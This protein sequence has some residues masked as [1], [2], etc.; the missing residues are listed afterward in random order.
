MISL[1][2]EDYCGNC[3]EFEPDLEKWDISVGEKKFHNTAITC[4]HAERCKS[5]ANYIQEELHEQS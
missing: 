2:I 1:N 5:I 3:D 4:K